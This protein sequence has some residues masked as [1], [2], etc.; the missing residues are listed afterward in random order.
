LK[1]TTTGT[2]EKYQTDLNSRCDLIIEYL[3]E[4]DLPNCKVLCIL[5][6]AV[7]CLDNKPGEDKKDYSSFLMEKAVKERIP[8]PGFGHVLKAAK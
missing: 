3:D 5:I 1:Y 2:L 4:I 8:S 7:S 6:I